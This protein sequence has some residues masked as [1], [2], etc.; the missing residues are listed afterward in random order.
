MMSSQRELEIIYSSDNE[1]ANSF[2]D[3][4]LPY[5]FVAA[6]LGKI[7]GKLF[8]EKDCFGYVLPGKDIDSHTIRYY[9]NRPVFAALD[10]SYDYD[11][12]K[13]KFEDFAEETISG[14]FG[15][16]IVHPD[17]QTAIKARLLQ[18]Q[19]WGIHDNS[20]LYPVDLYNPRSGLATRLVVKS[21]SD[22]VQ[23]FLFGFYGKGKKWLGDVKESANEITWIESQLLGVDPSVRKTGIAKL[24]KITQLKEAQA[25]NIPLIHWTVDPLQF[26]NA[27]L[28]FNS[29][30]GVAVEYY[31]DYYPV[32]NELN[33]LKT[34]RFGISW[35]T[36]SERANKFVKEKPKYPSYEE[37][38]NTSGVK[39]VK[40]IDENG[41][42]FSAES[43]TP[44]GSL[45]LIQIPTN[46]T[47]LLKNSIQQASIWRRSS[48]RIFSKIIGAEEG[49]YIITGVISNKN[50][51]FAYLLAHKNEGT[52]IE[53]IVNGD[54]L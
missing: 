22:E 29:L 54:L 37:L 42:E 2:R 51:N 40:P 52:N 24:L 8:L 39:V 34:S 1:L 12:E 38:A 5:H 21:D 31:S 9:G 48:D 18:K 13:A 43:W 20:Q 26:P 50:E 53:L 25:E 28:N 3:Q 17:R 33:P 23:G 30:G 45:L 15:V 14:D 7:G 27:K 6:T 44:K 36:T 19:I 46:W 4:L 47:D 10:N 32:R 49:K 16:R 41:N 11:V 35:L